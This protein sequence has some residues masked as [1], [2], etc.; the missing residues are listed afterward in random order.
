MQT[1]FLWLEL[2]IKQI[3]NDYWIHIPALCYITMPA[4]YNQLEVAEHTA[5]TMHAPEANK[6]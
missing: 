3:N 1:A 4:H 2:S 5:S 6:L